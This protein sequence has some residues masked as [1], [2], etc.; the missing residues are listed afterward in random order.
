MTGSE[1]EREEEEGGEE[2]VEEGVEEGEG[3]GGGRGGEGK[4]AG[5]KEEG[6]KKGYNNPNSSF[7]TIIKLTHHY[8]TGEG[9][10]FNLHMP[11]PIESTDSAIQHILYCTILYYTALYCTV[12]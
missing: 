6:G 9:L 3:E 11:Q 12:L 4:G 5:G 2:G 1:G 8:R 7:K 10:W